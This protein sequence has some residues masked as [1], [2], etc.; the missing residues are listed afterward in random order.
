MEVQRFWAIDSATSGA[1]AAAAASPPGQPDN[2]HSQQQPEVHAIARRFSLGLGSD[3]ASSGGASVGVVGGVG[4]GAEAE[5]SWVVMPV[6]EQPTL[7]SNC[8]MEFKAG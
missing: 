8:R 1:A 7:C 6:L 5:R 4:C 3:V 2:S